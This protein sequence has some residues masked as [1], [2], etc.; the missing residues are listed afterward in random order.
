[1][2]FVLLGLPVAPVWCELACP[3]EHAGGATKAES[4]VAH[5]A[6]PCHEASSHVATGRSGA[7]SM[8]AAAEVGCDHPSM[9]SARLPDARAIAPAPVSVALV[10]HLA[11]FAPAIAGRLHRPGGGGRRAPP[12]GPTFSLVLR[13]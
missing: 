10:S 7:S 3:Q 1:M 4:A 11:P 13:I 6:P 9:Q 12:R 5:E 2:L 8:A